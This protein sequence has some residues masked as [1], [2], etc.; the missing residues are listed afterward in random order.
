MM[1]LSCVLCLIISLITH[2]T[3]IDSWR[4]SNAKVLIAAEL[5][6][7]PFEVQA[8]YGQ[9]YNNITCALGRIIVLP[10]TLLQFFP[11]I[12]HALFMNI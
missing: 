12:I 5:T 1:I 2:Q 8:S 6:C 4:K 11:P 9:C 10:I 3:E 7:S